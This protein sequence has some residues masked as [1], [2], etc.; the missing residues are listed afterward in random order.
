MLT[1]EIEGDE[2]F[3]EETQEFIE[4]E[5]AILHLEHSL[6]SLSKW[7]SKFK[8]P[9]LETDNKN[10]KEV[11][12]YIE[13]MLINQEQKTKLTGLSQKNLEQIHQYIES[14]ESATTFGSLPTKQYGRQETITAEL[15]YYWMIAFNIPF[16]CETW[17]LNRLFSL[18][19]I[20]NIKNGSN[21]KTNPKDIAARNRELNEQRRAQYGTSG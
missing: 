15:I 16:E 8:R 5:G 10:E 14:P 19:R 11:L 7:E 21:K 4:T 12:F 1:I 17:H 9:F 6:V 2:Y 13:C 18:I 20:C 3:D